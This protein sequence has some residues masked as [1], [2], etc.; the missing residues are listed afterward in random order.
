MALYGIILS[1]ILNH[2]SVCSTI[3]SYFKNTKPP[4][5]SYLCTRSIASTNFNYKATLRDIDVNRFMSDH[6]IY[7]L[8]MALHVYTNLL[9]ILLWAMYLLYTAVS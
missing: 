6:S 4:C 1:N 8:V 9:V 7:V 5:I 2:K 3:L